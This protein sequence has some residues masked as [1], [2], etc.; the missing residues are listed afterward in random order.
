MLN[1]KRWGL[2]DQ[3]IIFLSSSSDMLEEERMCL[4]D[5]EEQWNLNKHLDNPIKIIKW[6]PLNKS[7]TLNETFQSGIDPY[8]ISSHLIIFFVLKQGGSTY[9]Y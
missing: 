7:H 3:T 6:E 8:I 5:F 4:K 9:K 2:M 1:I